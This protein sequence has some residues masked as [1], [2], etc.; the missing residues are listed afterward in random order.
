MLKQRANG[1]RQQTQ[2]KSRR[3]INTKASSLLCGASVDLSEF[4]VAK[5]TS[6]LQFVACPASL[7]NGAANALDLTGLRSDPSIQPMSQAPDRRR[8]ATKDLAQIQR[9]TVFCGQIPELLS[10]LKTPGSH[11]SIPTSPD[12]QFD[13]CTDTDTYQVAGRRVI[14]CMRQGSR[15]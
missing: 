3:I 5:Q 12:V 4:G 14:L 15:L 9:R 13:C 10:S 2:T 6:G 7:H 1:S 8:L 11:L